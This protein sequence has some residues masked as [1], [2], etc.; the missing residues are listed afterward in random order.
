MPV[1][2]SYSEMDYDVSPRSR[3][4]GI[5]RMGSE[6]SGF[7]SRSRNSN[8]DDD[9]MNYMSHE[10]KECILFFE[11]TLDSLKDDLE[12]S[13][14]ICSVKSEDPTTPTQINSGNEE[15]IDLVA[16]R[17]PTTESI[18]KYD[19]VL[20]VDQDCDAPRKEEVRTIEKKPQLKQSAPPL[21]AK[22]AAP[23]PFKKQRSFERTSP[24]S[25]MELARLPYS[26][27]RPPGS[28]P[29]PVVIAQKI[30]E[31]QVGNGTTSP[32]SPAESKRFTYEK[33]QINST[34]PTESQEFHYKNAKLQ[35]FPSNISISVP[36][37][38][39]SDTISKAAVKVQERKAQVLANLG[40]TSLLVAELDDQQQKVVP[41]RRSLSF[42]EAVS[43]QT[44]GGA[45]PKL[46]P[47]KEYDATD[48]NI[49]NGF[50]SKVRNSP[51]AQSL[52]MSPVSNGTPV[53]SPVPVTPP[54][55]ALSPKPETKG[56]PHPS[57]KLNT[58]G[59]HRSRSVQKPSGFRPQGVTVQFSGRGASDESR[60][61]A[62]RK[63]GLLRNN[64]VQ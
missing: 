10:E 8:L 5:E 48:S 51:S 57:T 44:K 19:N 20:P 34:S 1:E 33:D 43:I 49:P 45:L 13:C 22:N 37:R 17:S 7:G 55:K 35:R 64:D 46:G 36:S 61:E 58:S 54:L 60:K 16:T 30:A 28:V 12:E 14:S 18:P 42:K 53:A 15:I 56:I 63:L 25:K 21:P 50:N 6:D 23:A 38:G 32:V 2:S 52:Q 27:D 59:I 62:L 41:P 31:K 24:E 26:L 47:V 39:Y 29:T 40:G 4:P 11:T 3:L 9:F